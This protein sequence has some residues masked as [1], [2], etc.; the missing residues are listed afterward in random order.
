V[1]KEG[2][3]LPYERRQVRWADPGREIVQEALQCV[4]VRLDSRTAQGTLEQCG[5]KLHDERVVGGGRI[6]H[7]GSACVSAGVLQRL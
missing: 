4:L 7:R 6:C 2:E 5:D 3:W 1:V